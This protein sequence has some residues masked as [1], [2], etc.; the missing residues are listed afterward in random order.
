LA[1]I[2]VHGSTLF[3]YGQ[4]YVQLQTDSQRKGAVLSWM[5]VEMVVEPGLQAEENVLKILRC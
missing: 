4:Q 1:E 2:A 3:P 5:V